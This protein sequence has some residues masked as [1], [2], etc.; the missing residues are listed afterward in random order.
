MKTLHTSQHYAAYQHPVA[1]LIV[2]STRKAGG[3]RLAPGH[4]QYADY[5]EAFENA[6]DAVEADSLCRALLN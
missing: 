2:Q 1:G 6:I 3:A 4:P 5:V